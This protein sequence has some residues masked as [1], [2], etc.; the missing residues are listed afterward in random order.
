MARRTAKQ[1]ADA[2]IAARGIVADA[3]RA[4]GV[5]RSSVHRAINRYQTVADARD[6]AREAQIDR[7]ESKLLNEIDN[8]NIT[9]IIFY[10]KTQAKHRGYS[11]RQ[12]ITGA[13][14]GPVQIQTWENVMTIDIDDDEASSDFD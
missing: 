4:L 7:V 9:A 12:E 6:D 5:D 11:E 3:A 8:G 10:L 13:N 1:Y 14:G 2:L